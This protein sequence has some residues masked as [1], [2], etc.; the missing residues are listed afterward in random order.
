M[1][2]ASVR[3]PTVACRIVL[4]SMSLGLNSAIR[5]SD[6]RLQS[7]DDVG[8]RLALGSCGEGECHAVFEHGLGQFEHVVDGWSE[9]A[10][11]KGACADG[12]H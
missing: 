8:D 11:K 3:A 10:I 5:L 9:A 2:S 1:A 12:E 6:A 7:P 4:V